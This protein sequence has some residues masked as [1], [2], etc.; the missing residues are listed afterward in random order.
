[1]GKTRGILYECD[2]PD[3]KKVEAVHLPFGEQ[4]KL[5]FGWIELTQTDITY[6]FCS[7]EHLL[8]YSRTRV[9]Y[10]TGGPLFG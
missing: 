3:C 4:T 10:R 8:R 9:E 6:I 7:W 1:M 2:L 5:P